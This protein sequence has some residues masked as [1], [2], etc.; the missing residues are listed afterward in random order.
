MTLT[1]ERRVAADSPDHIMPW[2]TRHDSFTNLRFNKKLWRLYPPTQV[3]NLLDLGCAGG[4]FVRSCINDG[5]FGIGLEGSD[6]SQ[7]HRR[8]AWAL[9]EDALFTC[10]ITRPFSLRKDGQPV[11]FDIITAWEVAEHLK[12][13]DLP[14][15][16]HNVHSHLALGGLWI[17]SITNQEDVVGGIRLHQ[18]VQPQS[19]WRQKFESLRFQTAD[20]FLDYFAGQFVRGAKADSEISFHL[21]LTNDQSKT[22]PVPHVPLSHKMLDAWIG[23]APQQIIHKLVIG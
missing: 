21:V 19:W 13:E 10:D 20:R 17:L 5:H 15:L 9:I 12:P 7:R 14:A 1:A 16:A 18:T 4:E 11:K 23:S 6:W 22:P 8:A 3:V 2:G